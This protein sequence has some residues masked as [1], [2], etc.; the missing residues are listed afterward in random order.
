MTDI[1]TPHNPLYLREQSLR[2]SIELL[3]F[4]YRDFTAEADA[5]LAGQGLG[6]AHHRVIYFVGANPGLPVSALLDILKI[7]KQSLSRV[8]SRLLEQ[9]Y[10]R[11]DRGSRDRRQRLLHLTDKGKALEAELTKAQRE[12]F[13]TAF[14]D[15][16]MDAVDGFQTVLTYLVDQATRNQ[17]RV[18]PG[19][20]IIAS[21]KPHAAGK[22][23]RK[24]ISAY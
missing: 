10:I 17:L 22:P 20:G 5:M 14:K 21:K 2:Y 13:A 8:L 18:P 24:R 3:F 4:A 1:K 6:R 11:Q 9:G 23:Q 15:A 16:G 19:A 12:R 7:T